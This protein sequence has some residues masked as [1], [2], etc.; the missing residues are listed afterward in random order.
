MPLKE[1]DVSE[2]ELELIEK[3]AEK[4]SDSDFDFLAMTLLHI[5]KPISWIGGELSHFFLAPYLPLLEDKGYEF[6]DTFEKR[7]NLDRTIKRVEALNKEKHREKK[8]KK[9][10]SILSRLRKSFPFNKQII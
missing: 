7:E 2:R 4:I 1:H 9:G 5:M 8:R 10:R 6:I 3:V